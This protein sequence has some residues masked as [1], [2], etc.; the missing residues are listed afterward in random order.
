MRHSLLRSTDTFPLNF[1]LDLFA[2]RPSYNSRS[3]IP[4]YSKGPERSQTSIERASFMTM[5]IRERSVV[6]SFFQPSA[7]FRAWDRLTQVLG[8]ITHTLTLTLTF[9]HI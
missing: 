9:T 3:S 1:F 2:L 5:L 7:F 6:D 8:C 4:L